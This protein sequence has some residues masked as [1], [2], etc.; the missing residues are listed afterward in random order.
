MP[1]APSTIDSQILAI[2][3][4]TLNFNQ[5]IYFGGDQH[6]P[7][8]SAEHQFD[9]TRLFDCSTGTV[10]KVPS[11]SFDVFCSGHALTTD[12]T[13][14]VAGGTASFP[15]PGLALHH[16]HFP[17]LRDSAICRYEGPGTFRWVKTA[18]F[19]PGPAAPICRPGQDPDAD[20]CAAPEN[21]GK[22]GGRWYPT[23]LTLATGEVIAIG[24]H[25]GAG[26]KNHDNYIPEVFTPTPTPGGQWHRLGSFDD[27][28]QDHLFLIHGVPYYPRAHLLPTGDVVLTSPAALQTNTLTVN[29]QPFSAAF[30]PVCEFTPGRDGVDGEYMGWS[31]QSVLLPL[32][33]EKEFA[34]R[35]LLCGG[36]DPWLLDLSAWQPG[37][38]QAGQ[39]DWQRT[40]ARELT[41]SPRR[42]NGLAVLLPTGE[43]LAVGGVQA[44]QSGPDLV[45]LD[46]KAVKAPEIFNPDTNK[47][48]ALTSA[49][50]I[51]PVVRNYHSVALLMPDGRVW[52]AGSDKDAATG[53]AAAQHKIELYEPWYY[54]MS[55][56]PTITQAPD[57]I[58]PAETFTISTTQA[59]QI[60]RVAILRCTTCTHAFNPDQRYVSMTFRHAGGDQ[61]RVTAPPNN[62]IMPPGLYF[63]YTINDQGLP[64]VGVV[65]HASPDPETQ[66]EHDWNSLLHG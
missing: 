51:E 19:N 15:A 54:R 13:L 28:A 49:N 32:L 10:T 43:V 33:V 36:R 62:S 18:D 30:N 37:H 47:W 41:D 6:D 46:S 52:V 8:L 56:R 16:M 1:W 2:H 66:S 39:I 9:A 23:L 58:L 12:G 17:G 29:R 3:A 50:E 38:T 4:A 61:L 22:T 63:I 40:N 14:V 60:K 24:G 45:T 57:R 26:D 20:Q 5:I 35:I 64:S 44:F 42:A 25:P 7:Q 53:V 65:T 48:S 59:D 34:P 21:A 27:P 55:P 11:P 31:E